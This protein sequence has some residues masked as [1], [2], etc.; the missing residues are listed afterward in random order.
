MSLKLTSN[1][2][3]I[4]LI[5]LAHSARLQTATSSVDA[6]EVLEDPGD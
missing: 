4:P 2:I 1:R 5:C 3:L 6:P